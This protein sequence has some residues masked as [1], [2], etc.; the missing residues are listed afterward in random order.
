M[1]KCKKC[2]VEIKFVISE[3][4]MFSISKSKI[5]SLLKNEKNIIIKKYVCSCSELDND[6][7]L[8]NIATWE[9]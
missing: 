9:D 4:K 8:E 5:I 3:A 6:I 2:G 7:E 1:W